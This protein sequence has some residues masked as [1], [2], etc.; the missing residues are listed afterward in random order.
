LHGKVIIL[1]FFGVCPHVL[2]SLQHLDQPTVL[3]FMVTG[4]P[5]DG[6][7]V[8]TCQ[9]ADESTQR[10]VASGPAAQFVATADAGTYVA[11]TML[12]TFGKSGLYS[13][14]FVVGGV[15][16]YRGY[17]RVSQSALFTNAGPSSR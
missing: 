4:G 7:F 1:G 6:T 5:G 11:S 10:T 17:F 9:V 8:G 2:V 3:T 13:L 12:L 16:Q 15:E 14:R